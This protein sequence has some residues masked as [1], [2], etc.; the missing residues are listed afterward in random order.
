MQIKKE[1]ERNHGGLG[2]GDSEGKIH[3]LYRFADGWAYLCADLL[4]QIKTTHRV[5]HSA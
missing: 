4:G 1:R 2:R 3:G 5:L